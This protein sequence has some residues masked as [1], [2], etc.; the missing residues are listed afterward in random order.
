ML[1]ASG[2]GL[3]GRMF[4][5]GLTRGDGGIGFASSILAGSKSEL[6]DHFGVVAMHCALRFFGSVG[7]VV[8][9]FRFLVMPRWK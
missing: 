4:A 1:I 8:S 7:G 5:I 6:V 2:C 3:A 9:C